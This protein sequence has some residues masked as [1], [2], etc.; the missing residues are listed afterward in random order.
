MRTWAL[1]GAARLGPGARGVHWAVLAAT[2][3]STGGDSFE[4]SV[5]KTSSGITAGCAGGADDGKEFHCTFLRFRYDASGLRTPRLPSGNGSACAST[6]VTHATV[7]SAARAVAFSLVDGRARPGVLEAER[8]E[9]DQGTPGF[10]LALLL[11]PDAA[12]PAESLIPPHD[13][14]GWAPPTLRS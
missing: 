8:R 6:E 4:E 13:L 5:L 11:P 3:R 2:G 12:P 7:G 10:L 1:P 9:F 14:A